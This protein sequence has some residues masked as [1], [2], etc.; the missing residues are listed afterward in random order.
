MK[1]LLCHSYYTQRGGEDR[2]F[3]E[4]R[5]LL[6]ANGNEVIEYVR[7]NEEL[8]GRGKFA[9]AATTLWNRQAGREVAALIE[10][11]RPDVLHATNTFPLISPSVCDV[12][13]RAGVAVVQA[14]RNYRLLCANSYLMRDGQPCEACVGKTVPLPA[15]QHRCYRDSAAASAVVAAMQVYHRTVGVWRNR[16][17][18]FF[19]LTQF[20]RQ[21][22]VDAGLPANRIHVKY[23]SVSPDPGVGDGNGGYAVFVGRL[24]P[25]K[26][27]GTVLAAWQANREL[28]PLVIVGDGPL[29]GEVDAA[30]S[31][32]ARITV[33]GELSNAEAQRVI[34]AASL[35]VMPS[36]WYETFGRTIAEAY[37]TGTPVV[38]SRLGAMAELVEED[39]AG[40][41]FAPGDAA[42][43]AR[44][45]AALTSL[46]AEERAAMRRRARQAY[47][48]QFTPAHNYRRL[49]EIYDLALASASARRG[50]PAST[51]R[52]AP[53]NQHAEPPAHAVEPRKQ[54]IA[55]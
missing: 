3:E 5:E 47:E 6:Q 29:R 2:S 41:L 42:D 12:A 55:V 49:L 38:A 43:L 17:D 15:I 1:V 31:R 54:P 48:Q 53:L 4:E 32:D 33:R 13:H 7:S 28:P 45:V 8:L 10:R 51:A 20:A 16:V 52:S 26:G 21:K 30:A 14:L 50:A 46:P 9:S 27:V 34:G 35:L 19:T 36:L 11:H 22:F 23:N 44:Q 39:I 25:E 18:T 24:S 37:A 40:K